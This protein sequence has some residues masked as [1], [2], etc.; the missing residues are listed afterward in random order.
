MSESLSPEAIAKLFAAAE[1]GEPMQAEPEQRR[2]SVRKLDFA[3]P[4]AL[5]KA[6]QS[7]IERA[8][9]AFCRNAAEHLAEDF[10]AP[11][12][13]E[14]IGSSQLTWRAALEDLPGGS[15]RCV[16]ECSAGEAI[17]LCVEQGLVLRI[18]DG[19]LGGDFKHAQT[20]R[21]LSPVDLAL[22]GDVLD[23]LVATLSEVWEELLG[24]RLSVLQLEIAGSALEKLPSFEPSFELAIEVRDEGFSST[25]LLLVPNSALQTAT[26]SLLGGAHELPSEELDAEAA[27]MR[28]VLAPVRVEVRA[29]VGAAE[30]RLGEVVSLKPGDLVRLGPARNGRMVIGERRM[31]E[32]SL[33]RAG[34]RR[35]VKV[36]PNGGGL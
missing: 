17:L 24:L 6:E 23:R 11:V 4:A 26:K 21:E 32:L 3:R 5:S 27:R 13:L 18:I 2:R 25:I 15:V 33:G 12:T 1:T 8:H 7:R 19:L 14:V 29:E 22:A 20:P 9:A 31:H 16:A 10:A 30:M 35:A 28:T 34:K 36:V